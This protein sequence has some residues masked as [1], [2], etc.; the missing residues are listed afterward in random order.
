M[1]KT[2]ILLTF[3]REDC[4]E[5]AKAID[6]ILTSFTELGITPTVSVEEFEDE[7]G[8]PVIYFP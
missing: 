2:A 6:A 7:F 1:K 4:P 5:W 8:G 3:D